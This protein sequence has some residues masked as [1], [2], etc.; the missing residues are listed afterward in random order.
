MNNNCTSIRIEIFPSLYI[1]KPNGFTTFITTS[2][3][4]ILRVKLLQALVAEVQLLIQYRDVRSG[5]KWNMTTPT[6]YA[7]SEE[8][9]FF[10]GQENVP[11]EIFTVAVALVAGPTTGP[12]LFDPKVHGRCAS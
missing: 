1:G 4:V 12:L 2:R 10:N 11:F 7:L 3:G 9:V 8:I 6:R 5:M